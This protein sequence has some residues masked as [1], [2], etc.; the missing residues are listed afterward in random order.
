L[1]GLTSTIEN[2][3]HEMTVKHT[4]SEMAATIDRNSNCK[5]VAEFVTYIK[6][7][8]E[9]SNNSWRS[10]A[11]AFAEASDMYGSGSD[12]YRQLLIATNFSKSKA[13]KLVA[14]ATSKRLK[15]YE[16]PLRCVQSWSTLY[17]VTTLDDAQFALLVAQYFTFGAN[18]CHVLTEASIKA[19]KRVETQKSPFKRV[20]HIMIDE[21]ALVA[22]EVSDEDYELFQ[23]ALKKF[24]TISAYFKVVES[25]IFD[26]QTS[27]FEK[28]L[29]LKMR[30]L[31]KRR[32][33][34]II[35]NQMKSKKSVDKSFNET[36]KQYLLNSF[37]MSRE[38]LIAMID[39]GEIDAAFVAIGA[40]IKNNLFMNEALKELNQTR[41]KC[42]S[43]AYARQNKNPNLAYWSV[44]GKAKIAAAKAAAEAAAKA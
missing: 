31:A 10:I 29:N 20:A 2:G 21:D 22:G 41:K 40:V 37:N 15:T 33:D 17:E 26:G 11:A 18:P 16:K 4:T 6:Q 43:R 14:I 34:F 24:E 27:L 12:A 9:I 13:S 38:E 35:E 30:T 44:R 8:L 7:Q 25:D 36:Q 28:Q 42:A 3:K 19:F 39:A 32:L 5:S 23:E 1:N